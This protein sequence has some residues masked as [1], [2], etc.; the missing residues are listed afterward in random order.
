[1]KV[2]IFERSLY[3]SSAILLVVQFIMVFFVPRSISSLTLEVFAWFF[4][5]V[6]MGLLFLPINTL[7]R[8]GEISGGRDYTQTHKL[9]NTGIYALVRHPQ[10]L[11]WLLMHLTLILFNVRWP[12][13]VA[14][15]L[16]ASILARIAYN[17]DRR[18]VEKFGDDY[19]A[20][21]RRVPRLN[22]IRGVIRYFQR[23]A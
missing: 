1:M 3:Y 17:E 12:T 9:V 15:V 21:I 20:Y 23:K 6:S 10:Y 18:L 8:L 4:W 5:L 7:R 14:G 13:A 19:V 22:L 16:G 11:G 2:S